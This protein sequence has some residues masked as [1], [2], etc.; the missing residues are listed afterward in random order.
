M[1]GTFVLLREGD[2]SGTHTVTLNLQG[3]TGNFPPPHE[4]FASPPTDHPTDET[5]YIVYDQFIRRHFINGFPDGTFQPDGH[6]TRAE[7]MQVL[8]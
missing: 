2:T 5:I 8:N 1:A 3:G 6:M 7:M 4:P